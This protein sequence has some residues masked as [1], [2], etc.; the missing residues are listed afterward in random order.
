MLISVV[1][2]VQRKLWHCLQW[3]RELYGGTEQQGV[4][5]GGIWGVT[6]DRTGLLFGV[7]LQ[8]FLKIVTLKFVFEWD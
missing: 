5:V 6:R 2:Q 7:I 3:G 1:S 4:L 8:E